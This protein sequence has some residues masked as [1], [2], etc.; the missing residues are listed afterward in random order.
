VLVG[1]LIGIPVGIALIAVVNHG[2]TMTY[3]PLWLLAVVPGTMLVI[4][5]LT[6]IPSRLA[7]RRSMAEI[8]QAE[9]A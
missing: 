6:A 8:L 5:G 2:A 3:P 7:A 9:L 1:A 4:A